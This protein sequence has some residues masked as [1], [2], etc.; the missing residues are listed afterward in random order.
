MNYHANFSLKPQNPST[1]L[2]TKKPPTLLLISSNYLSQPK[3][4][5]T[6]IIALSS[7]TQKTQENNQKLSSP[8]S[9]NVEFKTKGGCKLGIARYPDFVYD[10]EGGFGSGSGKNESNGK[11][12]VEF[13]VDKLYVPP[14]TSGT[15]KFL[16]LPL[17][18]FLR[19]DIV[20]EIFKGCIDQESGKVDLE[21]R[22][23]FWFSM[24]TIYK[25]P[26]LLVS[27]NLTS[28]ESQGKLRKGRGQRMEKDGNCM[29][30]GV[31][32]V[33]PIDDLFMNTFLGLPTECLAVMNATISL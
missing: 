20:P 15:T 27:T 21:F 33:D 4:H 24:G 32:T 25:A 11:I 10:A 9:Y 19:I 29:L 30:V 18:P 13:D 2:P 12:L 23:K 8:N 17:P 14:L 26:P 31:A 22:A 3:L 28:E 16:G 6:H 5:K 7:S 1:K